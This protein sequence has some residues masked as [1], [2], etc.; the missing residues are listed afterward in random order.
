[1]NPRIFSQAMSEIDSRYVEEAACYQ[2][3][4]GKYGWI[5]WAAACLALTVAAGVCVARC[6]QQNQLTPSDDSVKAT[7]RYIDELDPPYS[8]VSA[9]YELIYLTEEELF[10]RFDTAIFKG[11][12]LEINNIELNF[13]GS[14]EYRAIAQIQVE[15]VYRGPCNA[16]DTVSVLLQCP[17]MEGIWVEDTDM[18]SRMRVGMTGIFMPV[19]FEEDAIWEEAGAVLVMKDIADGRFPDGMRYAFLKDGG[20]VFARSVYKSICGATTLDEVEEF[21]LNMIGS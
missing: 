13:N 1:M 19:F 20:L 15:T 18:I 17:I 6:R 4:A 9:S 12:V 21:I 10:T 14:I 8:Q 5:R 2:K 3:R 16:G 11:T 7:V